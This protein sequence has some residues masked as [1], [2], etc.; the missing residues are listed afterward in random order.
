MAQQTVE[1]A[2]QAVTDARSEANKVKMTSF[3]FVC[4]DVW[5]CMF[6]VDSRQVPALTAEIDKLKSQLRDAAAALA[7]AGD[8]ERAKV[9]RM[10]AQVEGLQAQCQKMQE[11]S[12]ILL[13][14]QKQVSC[15]LQPQWLVPWL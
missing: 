2:E 7:V 13:D 1:V 5:R 4:V 6:T 12:L 10:E 14:K 15:P 9:T 11:Q 3:C 8:G